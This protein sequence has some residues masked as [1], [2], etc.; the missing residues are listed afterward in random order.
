[1]TC[2]FLNF[3]AGFFLFQMAG[4]ADADDEGALCRFDHVET[5]RPVGGPP[6]LQSPPSRATVPGDR[7]QRDVVLH[8]HAEERR[9]DLHQFAL[10]D[11]V[12]GYGWDLGLWWDHLLLRSDHSV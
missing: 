12:R 8:L 4:L 3:L 9:G 6:A 2:G 11:L 5:S 7:G 10:D 1:M